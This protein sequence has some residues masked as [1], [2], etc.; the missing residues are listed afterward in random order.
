MQT[1]RNA[2][3]VAR[4]KRP[5]LGLSRVIKIKNPEKYLHSAARKKT[6]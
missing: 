3:R 4:G 1:I 5:G 2:F 6:R